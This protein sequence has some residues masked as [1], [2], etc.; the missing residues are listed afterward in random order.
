MLERSCRDRG[1]EYLDKQVLFF[2]V[3]VRYYAGI[4]GEGLLARSSYPHPATARSS[5]ARATLVSEQAY[6]GVI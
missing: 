4:V 3:A 6:Y 5:V 2:I 1:A